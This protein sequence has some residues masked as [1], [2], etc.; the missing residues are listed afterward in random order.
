MLFRSDVE[1]IVGF[2]STIPRAPDGFFQVSTALVEVVESTAATSVVG[3]SGAVPMAMGFEVSE[4]PLTPSAL[5][6]KTRNI[7]VCA[8]V[9]F[10]TVALVVV[11]T[12][13]TVVQVLP[14]SVE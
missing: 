6:A 13:A 5:V 12:G 9:R 14:L 2:A 1:S 4:L 7:Y 8:T 3:A 11:E 10:E